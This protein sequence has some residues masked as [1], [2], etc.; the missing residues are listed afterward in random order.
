[1]EFTFCLDFSLF[2]LEIHLLNRIDRSFVNHSS[3]SSICSPTRARMPKREIRQANEERTGMFPKSFEDE[4]FDHR[5]HL[6]E[7]YASP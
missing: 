1:M 2:V 3:G 4:Q 7:E 6:L 5:T